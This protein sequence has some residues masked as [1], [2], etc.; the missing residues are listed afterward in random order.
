MKKCTFFANEAHCRKKSN[1]SKEISI[2]KQVLDPYRYAHFLPA[3]IQYPVI[4]AVVT[5]AKGMDN[6]RKRNEGQHLNYKQH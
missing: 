2:C 6:T 4:K 3:D 1:F 5:E